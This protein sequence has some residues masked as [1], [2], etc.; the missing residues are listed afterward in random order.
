MRATHKEILG[1]TP[2]PADA[3]AMTAADLAAFEERKANGGRDPLD[4]WFEVSTAIE[5]ERMSN[6]MIRAGAMMESLFKNPPKFFTAAAA[7]VGAKRKAEVR[8]SGK[9]VGVVKLSLGDAPSDGS[10]MPNPQPVKVTGILVDELTDKPEPERLS[11]SLLLSLA[12]AGVPIQCYSEHL[13]VWQEL[14]LEGA[15]HYCGHMYGRL[16]VAPDFVMNDAQVNVCRFHDIKIMVHKRCSGWVVSDVYENG[17]NY[18]PAQAERGIA[19]ERTPR[20]AHTETSPKLSHE[21]IKVLA[22]LGIPMQRRL[23][24]VT[25]DDTWV[26]VYVSRNWSP[27]AGTEYRVA[28]GGERF[29]N[30]NAAHAA[31]SAGIAVAYRQF[32][33]KKPL[34]RIIHPAYSNGGNYPQ[35]SPS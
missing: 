32:G 8:T 7:E 13:Q 22:G 1:F 31:H 23:T 11:R 34:V 29:P 35:E 16:R 28:P 27:A 20:V 3:K 33:P 12:L 19:N 18:E 14:D 24:C 21:Q 25:D 30:D 5:N 10:V 2:F 26:S 4:S 17:G 9:S 15:Q 6:V